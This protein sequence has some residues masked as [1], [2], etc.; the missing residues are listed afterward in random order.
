MKMPKSRMQREFES[1]VAMILS[2]MSEMTEDQLIELLAV[3]ST[4]RRR[5]DQELEEMTSSRINKTASY[6]KEGGN[7]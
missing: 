7:K 6:M 4:L 2:D 5:T 1:I 3:S